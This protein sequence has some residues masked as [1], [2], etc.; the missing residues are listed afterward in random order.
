[1]KAFLDF[2]K[3]NNAVPFLLFVVI[4]SAGA[5][6]ASSPKLREAVFTPSGT[7]S[8]SILPKKTDISQIAGKNFETYDLRMRIDSM[9]ENAEA[10]FVAYSYQTFEVLD[11]AWKEIR[12]TAKMEIPKALLGK[13]DLGTYIAEQAEQVIGREMAYLSEVQASLTKGSGAKTIDGKYASL[14]GTDVKAIPRATTDQQEESL[15]PESIPSPVSAPLIS[16]II[17]KEEINKMIVQAVSDF[18]AIDMSMP[19]D[20]TANDSEGVVAGES[21]PETENTQPNESEVI[22]MEPAEEESA[23][24]EEES[25]VEENIT[26]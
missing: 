4:L 25:S 21:V 15:S 24:S 11:G 9:T 13:R 14:V 5:A 8:T 22:D 20:I 26:Q 6:F 17:S 12:K 10:Y 2:L 19:P 23:P 18:L 1:M 16:Q 3:Y 7:E